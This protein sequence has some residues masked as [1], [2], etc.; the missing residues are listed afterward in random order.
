MEPGQKEKVQKPV[1]GWVP[2]LRKIQYK[3]ADEAEDL[4]LDAGLEEMS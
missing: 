4:V 2:A 3:P 1:G